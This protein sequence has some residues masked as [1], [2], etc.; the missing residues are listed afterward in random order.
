[1]RKLPKEFNKLGER[2]YQDIDE[3]ISTRPELVNFLLQGLSK[4]DRQRLKPF[5]DSIV[6]PN[7]CS[8]E[9]LLRLWHA[10][11]TSFYAL[12]SED[13]R[14]LLREIRAKLD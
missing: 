12:D 5:L 8:G 6:D 1:M 11:P 4:Q 10:T 7:R 9:E 2:F 13:L 3:E 14:L